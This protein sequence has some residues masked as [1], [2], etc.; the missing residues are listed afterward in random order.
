MVLGI[1]GFVLVFTGLTTT[2][3][4][5]TVPFYYDRPGLYVGI[6]TDR[7]PEI[8]HTIYL[9]WN[10][11]LVG[12]EAAMTLGYWEINTFPQSIVVFVV[13]IFA[14]LLTLHACNALV[15]VWGR[16]ATVTLQGGFDPVAAALK[17]SRE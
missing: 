10:Y 8:H 16:F 3:G 13:G 1:L 5:L 11:M 17:G 4:M 6:V 14:G 9:G 2:L 12:I 7:A 15:H